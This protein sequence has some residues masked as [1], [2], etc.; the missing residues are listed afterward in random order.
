MIQSPRLR[1]EGD[2][3]P[4]VI[5]PY[6]LPISEETGNPIKFEIT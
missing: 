1:S 6:I 3:Y 4:V 2:Q 5:Q